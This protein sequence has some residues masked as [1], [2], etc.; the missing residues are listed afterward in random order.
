MK[1]NEFKNLS[2][3]KMIKCLDEIDYKDYA[4]A[5]EVL[6]K[7]IEEGR[8]IRDKLLSLQ[9]PYNKSKG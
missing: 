1:L 3:H 6:N 4:K 8:A 5:A 9:A 7:K 2:T